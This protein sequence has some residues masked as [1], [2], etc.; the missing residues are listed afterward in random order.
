MQSET[1]CRVLPL[2]C[3]PVTHSH[4]PVE[5]APP[6]PAQ[7]PSVCHARAAY[8]SRPHGSGRRAA[9]AAGRTRRFAEDVGCRRM[10]IGGASA[11]EATGSVGVWKRTEKSGSA[12]RTF[13][14]GPLAK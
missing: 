5:Q 10:W 4:L 6:G 9:Q 8:A 11:P 2:G 3:G 12:M 1:P 14:A 13:Q 7:L